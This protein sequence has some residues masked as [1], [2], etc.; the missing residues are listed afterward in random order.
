MSFYSSHL[1]IDFDNQNVIYL[2]AIGNNE[3]GEPLFKFGKSADVYT[4]DVMHHRKL[5]D[6]FEILHVEKCERK[7][8]VEKALK[9]E[10]RMKKMLREIVVKGKRQTEVFTTDNIEEVKKMLSVLVA[11]HLRKSKEENAEQKE[12]QPTDAKTQLRIAKERRRE[13]KEKTKQM[14]LEL[15]LLRGKLELERMKLRTSLAERCEVEYTT[16][17]VKKI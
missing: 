10:L 3:K 11:K 14:E 2:A 4:R 12:E 8:H 6:T 9:R 16:R 1:L 13:A 15:A 5:F 7:D 17:R